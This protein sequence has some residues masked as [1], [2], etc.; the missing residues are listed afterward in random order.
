M[1]VHMCAHAYTYP[2]ISLEFCA[3]TTF[4]FPPGLKGLPG[5]QGVKG[6]PGDQGFPGTKGK[7]M[8]CIGR[9]HTDLRKY[10]SH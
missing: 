7:T 8:C 4:C 9:C 10:E 3:K 2:C 6:D 5:I 1:C